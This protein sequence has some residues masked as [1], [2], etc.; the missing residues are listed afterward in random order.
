LLSNSIDATVQNGT[1]WKGLSTTW[2]WYESQIDLMSE[3]NVYGMNVFSSSAFDTGM[4]NRQYALFQLKP[5]FIGFSGSG[6]RL[7]YWL[8]NVAG[9]KA[10]AHISSRSVSS[11][12]NASESTRGVRPR[13]LIG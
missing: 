4:D 11:A 6:R 8:K 9:A 13:F 3:A 10:F 12:A 1:G 7:S 2:G 5:E